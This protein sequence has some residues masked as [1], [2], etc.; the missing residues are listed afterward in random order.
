MPA[1]WLPGLS[2]RLAV[3]SASLEAVSSSAESD[4][5]GSSSRTAGV[6]F[7]AVLGDVTGNDSAGADDQ[8]AEFS[9]V[10]IFFAN[11]RMDDRSR[12]RRMTRLRCPAGQASPWRSNDHRYQQGPFRGR[13]RRIQRHR[14]SSRVGTGLPSGAGRF[15]RNLRR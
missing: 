3:E 14:N 12:L 7:R 1:N 10:R 8:L 5:S 15:L 4:S 11:G 13:T 2:L 9:E 6:G